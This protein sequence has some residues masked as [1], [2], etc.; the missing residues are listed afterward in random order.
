MSVAM[1]LRYVAFMLLALLVSSSTMAASAQDISATS[2]CSKEGVAN[3]LAPWYCN[4]KTGIDH[5]IQST[6]I[7]TSG[8]PG[9][10]AIGF[11][12]VMLSFSFAALI[13]MFG[14][15]LKNERL[16]TFGIGELYEALATAFM[17]GMFGF[18]A[19]V[20][21][22]ILPS[23]VT[24]TINPYDATLTYLSQ[25]INATST[26]HTKLAEIALVDGYYAS[27]QLQICNSISGGGGIVGSLLC[28]A[29]VAKIGSEALWFGFFWP[30][31]TIIEFLTGAIISLWLQY[32]LLI[33]FLYAAVPVFLI[34]GVILRAFIPTR[35]FG[36]MLMAIAIG[37]YFLLPMLFSIAYYLTNQSLTFQLNSAITNLD[38]YGSGTGAEQ[39]ALTPFSP[40]VTELSN[41]QDTFSSFWL[42]IAFFPAVNLSI[43]YAF[44]VQIAEIL[45]GR[46]RTSSKLRT[47]A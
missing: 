18:V 24:G 4:A 44:I 38:K 32:W 37:F 7:G 27:I 19:A 47:I 46:G 3:I 45:G 11:L 26:L 28:H 31:W 5:A 29:P 42:E 23:L 1:R 33:F 15:V 22:G 8:N 9:Y 2:Y 43:T 6:W 16:R 41:I 13:I 20:L 34:P 39:N 17:V 36:G 35:S 12:A 30:A 14:I 40:L 21:F 10:V 25:T